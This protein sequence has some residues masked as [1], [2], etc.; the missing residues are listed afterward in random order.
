VKEKVT[1]KKK[2][3]VKVVKKIIKKVVV[4]KEPKAAEEA[5]TSAEGADKKD[6]VKGE[7]KEEKEGGKE[8]EEGEEEEEE[9]VVEEEE[10]LEVEEEEL[11][12]GKEAEGKSGKVT[13]KAAGRGVSDE[14]S[15]KAGEVTSTYRTYIKLQCPHCRTRCVTFKVSI[16]LLDNL[17]AAVFAFCVPPSV[18]LAVPIVLIVACD[19][20]SFL[21]R[22]RSLQGVITH[23]MRCTKGLDI[24]LISLISSC[25][26]RS[27]HGCFQRFFIFFTL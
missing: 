17:K 25:W 24:R 8:L 18:H 27:I 20:S 2:R 6:E 26:I 11:E 19:T 4:K 15:K 1:E 10:E 12:N 23:D 16:I 13:M 9:E 5:A 3:P 22:K 7:G 14:G 21:R